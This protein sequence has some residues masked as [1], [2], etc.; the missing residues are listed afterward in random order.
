MAK[1]GVIP[2]KLAKYPIPVCS[3]CMHVKSTRKSWRS[4]T[5]TQQH[6]DEITAPGDLISVDQLIPPTPGFIAQMTGKLTKKRY[7]YATICVDQASRLG[8]VYFKKTST[9]KNLLKQRLRFS[10]MQETKAT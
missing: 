1:M 5:P 2:K 4:K 9:V 7:K 6:P 8:Y 10:R 3:A